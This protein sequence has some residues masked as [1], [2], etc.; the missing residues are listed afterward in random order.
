MA[1]EL[2]IGY[3]DKKIPINYYPLVGIREK[4][5]ENCVFIRIKGTGE[6]KYEEY[7]KAEEI[8]LANLIHNAAKKEREELY[9]VGIDK[10]KQTIIGEL[11]NGRLEIEIILEG[12][13]VFGK[14]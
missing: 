3:G 10:V 6:D 1:K 4:L 2:A 12:V 7:K 14:S 13:A 5:R 8:A 11:I 9:L